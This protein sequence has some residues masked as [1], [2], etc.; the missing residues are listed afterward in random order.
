MPI[1]L[2][3]ESESESEG[4]SSAFSS[5]RTKRGHDALG[6]S[7]RSVCVHESGWAGGWVIFLAIGQFFFK[8]FDFILKSRRKKENEK[9]TCTFSNFEFTILEFLSL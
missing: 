9:V 3:G 4:R 1:D 6:G 8:L 5:G 2:F 7:V